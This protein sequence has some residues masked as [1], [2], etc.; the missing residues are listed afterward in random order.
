MTMYDEYEIIS[1][2]IGREFTEDSELTEQ[3]IAIMSLKG[4]CPECLT[5][6]EIHTMDCTEFAIMIE[7]ALMEL[8]PKEKK[9]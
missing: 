2:I 9:N 6:N 1:E 3:D 5:E 7:A 4:V 8:H